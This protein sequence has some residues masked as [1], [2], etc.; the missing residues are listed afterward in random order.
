MSAPLPEPWHGLSEVFRG[1]AEYRALLEHP[2]RAVRLPLPA[3]AWA[4]ELLAQDLHCNLLVIVPHEADA[5]AWLAVELLGGSA[6]YFSAPSLSAYHETDVSLQVRAQESAAIHGVLEGRL[7]CLVCTPRAL[8]R[9]LPRPTDYLRGVVTLKV[10]EEVD[11]E[12]LLSHLV[13]YGYRRRDMVSEVGEVAVRGGIV[14]VFP[15]GCKGP[16]RVDLFGDTIESLRSFDTATQR[17]LEDRSDIALLPVTLFPAGVEEAAQLAD[18]LTP[19]VGVEAGSGVAERIEELRERGEFPGWESFLPLLFSETV[20]VLDLLGDALRI[21]VSPEALGAEVQLH[22]QQ[23]E[24]DFRAAAERQRLAV[25]P[26]VLEH[27]EPRVTELLEGS[28]IRI[29]GSDLGD[30]GLEGGDHRVDFAGTTTDLFHNQL[31]RFPHEVDIARARGDR[32][33][34]VS[35]SEHRH[36]LEEWLRGHEVEIGVGGAEL[37][38]GDLQRGFRLP[39]A[40]VV[41]YGERQLFPRVGPSRRRRQKKTAAFVSDLRDLRVGDYVVHA[42]HGIG[43]FAALRTMSGDLEVVPGLPPSLDELGR[44]DLPVPV[45]VMEIEYSNGRGL[46]VPLSRL[47]LVQRYS[48]MEGAGPRL[49]RLGG[50]SWSRTKSR[51]KRGMKKL[52]GDLLQLYAQRQLAKAQAMQP[53]SDLLAQF[54]AAFDFEPTEDQI[55]AIAE[56]KRDLEKER[57]MDRL[58]CGDVGFGKT[59]VAMRAAFKVV[60]SGYQV[61]VLAPTTILADQHLETFR[62]RFSEF[63]VEIQMVSRRRSAQEIRE[64]RDRVKEGGVDILIGTHRLLSS[65]ISIP[66]LGF[67]IVDEEQRFGV[68]QKEKLR[69]LKSSVHV[70]AMSATP[71][72]RTLQLSLAG[73]RDLS[74]IETA[75]RDRMAVETAIIPFTPELVREAIEFERERGGQVFYVYNRV[76]TIDRFAGYLREMIPDLKLTIGHGQMNENELARR[77]RAFKQG[78]Y[79]L[80]LATTIIENGIDISNVNTMIVHNADRFGLAQLYQLRGRVGRS[81]QLAYCYLL[82]PSDRALTDVSRKRLTALREFTELGAG[83]RVAARDLEI[84]GAGNLLGAEQSG[85]IAAVGIE[86]YLRMLEETVRELRGEVVDEG[87]SVALDLP[88]SMAIPHDYVRDANLRMELYRKLASGDVPED[89]LVAE[90]RDRFGPPPEAVYGLLRVAT[91]KRLAESMR[92]QSISASGR[93]LR[94]RMR[95]DARIDLDRLVRL[96][97]QRPGTEFSPQGVLTAELE[98][99]RGPVDMAQELLEELAA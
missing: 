50:S 60:D 14:D 8:F 22:A 84:R 17:S 37:V 90:L 77:M 86:T 83:F 21:A 91:L 63:P 58:L 62:A 24:R 45:E 15:P 92:I 1:S 29:E 48:G 51:V 78:D 61:A 73:V 97:S 40:G 2:V 65:D 32:L 10:G 99:G 6:S 68:A 26:E 38:D 52:A 46:L 13:R 12:P 25:P 70:L 64:I 5:L 67:L 79:D 95:T 16:V 66:N 76:E 11:L 4:G 33:L 80:L 53:D 9:K 89:E 81:R 59:E 20:T 98:D 23:L 75:P 34:I 31:P 28:E 42:D 54:D 41:V 71:V 19:A 47:D 7:R 43:R 36:R 82:V 88:V 56:I 30:G 94:I 44:G 18:L 74:L 87:P 35:P 93:K 49:D 96:V 57:P 72:P 39:L 69:E 27:P 55:D 85:H 3:S